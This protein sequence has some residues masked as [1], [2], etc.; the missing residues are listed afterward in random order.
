MCHAH[1]KGLV[2]TSTRA[3][4][5]LSMSWLFRGRR[6]CNWRMVNSLCWPCCLIKMFRFLGVCETIRWDLF[7]CATVALLHL[8]FPFLYFNLSYPWWCWSTSLVHYQSSAGD[9]AYPHT[10]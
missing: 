10:L 8:C 1:E 2:E 6:E 9:K 5:R 3:D 4:R 7:C